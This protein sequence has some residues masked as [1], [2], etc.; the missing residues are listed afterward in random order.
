MISDITEF[1]PFYQEIPNSSF[2]SSIFQKEEFN[3]E[4]LDKTENVK[5]VDYCQLIKEKNIKP[6]DIEP[7]NYLKHQ[8]IISRFMSSYTP[9]DRLFIVHQMGTGKTKVAIA[10]IEAIRKS[11]GS[12]KRAIV[13]AK[14][15]NLLDNF[16]TELVCRTDGSFFPADYTALKPDT[17]ERRINKLLNNFYDFSLVN[18]SYRFGYTFYQ[19]AKAVKQSTDEQIIENFSDHIIVVDEIH[20]IRDKDEIRSEQKKDQEAQRGE[21]IDIYKQ[22]HR[23]F[24]IA[25]NIKV[26]LMSGT[27]IRDTIDEIADTLNLLVPVSEQLPTG[28]DFLSE[29]FDKTDNHYSMKDEKVDYFKSLMKGK[30][31][32]LRAITSDVPKVFVGETLGKLEHFIADPVTMSKF[33]T[34]N[35]LRILN[36]DDN[37]SAK[38]SFWQN[39]IEASLFIF[40]DGQGKE[41]F[42]KYIT[43]KEQR[44]LGTNRTRRSYVMVP[45]LNDLFVGTE[46]EK[47]NVLSRYS[48]KYAK[49][50]RLILDNYRNKKSQFVYCNW[51]TGTGCILFALLLEKFG[52][53]KANGGETTPSMRYALF[54]GEK[55]N[56]TGDFQRIK[57]RFNQPDNKFGEYINVIIGSKVVTE[58]YS[59]FNIQVEH[60]LTWH[61]NYAETEQAEARGY[62]YGSHNE[63]I[64]AGVIPELKIYQYVT[65]PDT[66][67]KLDFSIDYRMATISENKDV[68]IKFIERYIKEASF[69]CALTYKRNLVMGEDGSRDCDYQACEYFCDDISPELY[70]DDEVDIDYSTYQLYYDQED[71]KKIQSEI[72]RIFQTEFKLSFS[73]IIQNFTEFT[74]FQIL[75][76]LQNLINNNIGIRNRYG[77]ISYLRESNNTYFLS[78]SFENNDP[79]S[80]YYSENII[81]RQKIL[82]NQLIAELQ[83]KIAPVIIEQIFDE[84][85][86][87][88][89]VPELLQRLPDDVRELILQ[90]SLQAEE[91]GLLKD[92][93]KRKMILENLRFYYDKIGDNLYASIFDTTR[94]R[95]LD[96]QSMT[97]TDCSQ[98]QLDTIRQFREQRKTRAAEQ[99]GGYY[100][101]YNATNDKFCILIP[102]TKT[103]LTA[104]GKQKASQ[105]PS[106][107]TCGTGSANKT[108]L[109]ELLVKVFKIDPPTENVP[110]SEVKGNQSIW[111]GIKARTKAQLI[112][113]IVGD[114]TTQDLYTEEELNEFPLEKIQVIE[115][116]RLLNKD[117][118]CNILK[119]WFDKQ[120]LLIQSKN[121][122]T[123]FKRKKDMV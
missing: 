97:W 38:N 78:N 47:L 112:Q 118:T 39:S 99:Y 110:D 37:N 113:V 58:G 98:S 105:I 120:G 50:I 114:K 67:N 108:K 41:G 66:E 8:T 93:P 30:V 20:N 26:L 74:T 25:R 27:P 59:F 85:T 73:Q 70:I 87:A 35:Y 88:T 100:G 52:F 64:K 4:K 103:A 28:K 80:D 121:C 45:A 82:Y 16:K 9:Y 54:T 95:C 77:Y 79:F 17:K 31:S 3:K 29:Y 115:Y 65:L 43:K 75:N 5:T 51:V 53:T 91:S 92:I 23:L 13:C 123:V 6:T 12:I 11:N 104:T 48:A 61:W 46:E 117:P 62:R 102:S 2:T 89:S 122:G 7:G 107:V 111:R 63:L 33:Q 24:H 40:P 90:N 42:S 71:L 22:L 69:D 72:I 106:G 83:L 36:E 21:I 1:L 18:K 56:T 96:T 15:N 60:I 68:S 76:A 116:W 14:N 84:K 19:L 101:L 57:N 10:V 94:L 81:T 55:S 34:E 44:I 109:I 49:A 119:N 32:Y 86:I